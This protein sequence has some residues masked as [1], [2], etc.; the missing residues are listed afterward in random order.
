[1]IPPPLALP[2]LKAGKQ[3]G[4]MK[5]IKKLVHRE[6][7]GGEKQVEQKKPSIDSR[8]AYVILQTKVS[9]A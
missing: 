1:V 3:A 9:P 4:N 7:Q 6:R 8:K 2:A 5:L